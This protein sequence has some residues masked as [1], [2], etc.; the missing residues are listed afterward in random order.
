MLVDI[1]PVDVR[2]AVGCG[3]GRADGVIAGVEG[4]IQ[5]LGRPGVQ[6]PVPLNARLALTTMPLTLIVIGRLVVVP[7]AN[8]KVNF[9]VL[10][11][12]TLTTHSTCCRPHCC[13]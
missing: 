9:A 6:A 10:A 3:R 5:A 11:C 1:Q 13:S 7:L 8:R 4:G 2:P 12:G